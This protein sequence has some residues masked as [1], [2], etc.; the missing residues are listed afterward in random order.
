MIKKAKQSFT[1]LAVFIFQFNFLQAQTDLKAWAAISVKIPVAKKISFDIEHLRGYNITTNW[2]N[3]FNQLQGRLEIKLNKKINLFFGDLIT[4]TPNSTE[5]KNRVF[6][7]I[8][9]KTKLGNLFRL[10]NGLQAEWNSKNENRF[11][12]RF[13]AS[14]RLYL[15]KRLTAMH[16][17]PSVT[18]FL[19][20]NGGGKGIQYYDDNKQPLVKQTPDGFHRGRILFNINSKISDRFNIGFY[21]MMQ[22]EFNFLNNINHSIN[23]Q[24]PLTGKITR[25]FDNY[26]VAGITLAI[27]LLKGNNGDPSLSSY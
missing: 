11:R 9:C 5:I 7:R 14:S 3:E 10:Q 8:T 19:F 20:Y 12:Y 6:S 26:N 18:G 24:N 22:R 4:A 25:P 1:I 21:Y 16:L 13:I 2:Q 15:K 27:N 23:Y 17:S